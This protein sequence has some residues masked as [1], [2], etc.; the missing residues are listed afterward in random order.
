[1]KH[2]NPMMKKL[3]IRRLAAGVAVLL[4]GGSFAIADIESQTGTVDGVAVTAAD[5]GGPAVQPENVMVNPPPWMAADPVVQPVNMPTDPQQAAMVKRGEY[6]ATAADCE[7]C[8]SIPTG[9]P[10]AGGQPLQSPVG[11]MVTP[12][13][14]P[15]KTYGIGS[16]TDDQFYAALHDGIAPGHSLLVFPKYLY[17]L[18]PWT[19]FS[20]LSRPDIMAIKAYLDTIPP[21]AQKNQPTQMS[22]P[23]TVRAGMLAWRILFFHPQPIQ[24]DPSWSPQVRNGA[25]LTLALA[26]CSECHSER[27]L[28]MA[29]EPSRYL[30]GGA[31]PAQSWY[32]P[33]ISS[34][35]T[36]G[37]GGWSPND[38]FQF[39]YRDGAVGSAGGAPFGP[40]R[41]VVDDSLSRLPPSDIQDIVAYLQT[42]TPA[43]QSRMPAPG[44][45]AT[46]L[47][48]SDGAGLYAENCARCHGDNGAG[49]T[50]NFPN[51][52]ANQVVWD[53]PAD[54]VNSMIL[55][56]FEPWHAGQSAMPAFSNV[57]DDQQIAEITNYI[58]TA[59]GNRGIA[60]DT[61]DQVNRQRVAASNFVTLSTG[62]TQGSLTGASVAGGA[63]AFDDISGQIELLGGRKNC[64]VSGE[65][66]DSDPAAP[67][68]MLS[69]VGNCAKGGSGFE[70]TV[71]LD[72]KIYPAPF[73][74]RDTVKGDEVT[75]LTISGKPVGSDLTFSTQIALGKVN[76]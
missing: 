3:T 1:M 22:F 72:G 41:L 37:V 60:D 57:L 48:N 54:D 27:N 35:K 49:V 36:D 19:A 64:M 39:L 33:N 16:W 25:Y 4:L 8:H 20:K 42:A 50:N 46:E 26:H 12:N 74:I 31:I 73:E 23:F 15:D 76:D 38:L 9:K 56:G 59:W 70:G 68:K 30:A 40:M 55:G 75:A 53:G 45:G 67:V 52:A 28:L 18:M 62:N 65:F 7:Y 66:R 10:Y 58:R 71:T 11:D 51:L 44:Q 2:K 69:L 29:V 24:Y 34:S 43:Q 17:P 61:A 47:A 14:T 13:I 63:A 5:P 32:A 6:L 21:V